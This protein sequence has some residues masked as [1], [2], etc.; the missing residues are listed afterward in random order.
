MSHPFKF[1]SLDELHSLDSPIVCV[2]TADTV[3]EFAENNCGGPLTD[4]ELRQF[5]HGSQEELF[6]N[7]LGWL[8]ESGQTSRAFA[9][10]VTRRHESQA[11]IAV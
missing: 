9:E 7:F 6:E 1:I 2:I 10:Q 8:N 4:E 3:Q 11:Q 5:H